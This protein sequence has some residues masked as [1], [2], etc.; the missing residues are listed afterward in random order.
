MRENRRA[1]V[2]RVWA[3][4]RPHPH[5]ILWKG[6]RIWFQRGPLREG[7]APCRLLEGNRRA[8]RRRVRRRREGVF[9]ARCPSNKRCRTPQ[10][11]VRP[12]NR[13]TSALWADLNPSAPSPR[14]RFP[15]RRERKCNRCGYFLFGQAPQVVQSPILHALWLSRTLAPFFLWNISFPRL[16]AHIANLLVIVYQPCR[17]AGTRRAQKQKTRVL[18]TRVCRVLFCG[19]FIVLPGTVY[20]NPLCSAPQRAVSTSSCLTPPLFLLLFYNNYFRLW[21]KSRCLL[22]FPNRPRSN[23]I[24]SGGDEKVPVA[25]KNHIGFI[26]LKALRE[27][28][29]N[30]W[31]SAIPNTFPDSRKSAPAPQPQIR[32][33]N[34]RY[35]AIAAGSNSP[36]AEGR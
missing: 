10:L 35:T 21:C 30:A 13:P 6:R 14:A 27:M 9:S 23:N 24:N 19:Q 29:Q 16:P 31:N 12:R 17:H 11:R 18:Q 32:N 3:S 28:S 8:C 34:A 33:V 4:M 15:A 5:H 22:V 25:K 36:H 20:D 1:R 7:C 26:P 2:N